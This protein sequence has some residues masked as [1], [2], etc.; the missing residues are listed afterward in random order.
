MY[1]IYK[2][3]PADTIETIAASFNISPANLYKLN[4]FNPEYILKEGTNIIVPKVSNEYFTYYTIK[5][6]DNLSK[7]A[8]EYETNA[9]LLALLNGLNKDDYIYPNQTIVVPQKDIGIYITQENDT[10]NEIIMGIKA[11]PIELLKQNPKIY[12]L[13][14]QIIIYKQN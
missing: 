8:N 1:E 3:G 7:I 13:P 12:V 2:V 9:K 4:G 11:N 10:I 14:E 6:G 5:N